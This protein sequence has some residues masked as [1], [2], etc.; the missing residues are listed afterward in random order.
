MYF[1]VICVW[2][3]H[4]KNTV[5]LNHHISSQELLDR[6]WWG[7]IFQV[8]RKNCRASNC[9]QSWRNKQTCITVFI[10]AILNSQEHSEC[11]GAKNICRKLYILVGLHLSNLVFN[12]TEPLHMN[13]IE[14]NARIIMM[15]VLITYLRNLHF[16]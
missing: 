7:L 9:W 16:L 6:F 5:P 15:K 14:F 8:L 11:Q 4:M 13:W 10:K 2:L 12:Y 1:C 3:M